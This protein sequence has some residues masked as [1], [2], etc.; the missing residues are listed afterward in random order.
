MKKLIAAAIAVAGIAALAACGGPAVGSEGAGGCSDSQPQPCVQTLGDPFFGVVTVK[1][2]PEVHPENKIRFAQTFIVN[3]EPRAISIELDL[4]KWDRYT[5]K[6][7]PDQSQGMARRL[8]KANLPPVGHKGRLVADYTCQQGRYKIKLIAWGITA[9]G[10]EQNPHR[11]AD[12]YPGT[13]NGK[14]LK[15]TRRSCKP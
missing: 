1:H 13:G 7:E 5:G 4:Y 2:H 3:E 11:K 10:G 8:T 12:W 9:S 6:F 15:V 14:Y